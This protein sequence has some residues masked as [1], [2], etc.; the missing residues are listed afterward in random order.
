MGHKVYISFKT[1]DEAYKTYIQAMKGLDYVD[2][3]LNVAIDSDDDDYIMQKIRSDYLS[4]STVTVHLIGNHGAESRGLYE[5]R[6][7]KKELQAS[8][9]HSA[10]NTKNGILGIVLPHANPYIY[11][12]T[13]NCSSCLGSHNHVAISDNTTISEFRYNYYIPHNKCAHHEDDRFCVLVAWDDF[14]KNPNFYIDQAYDKRSAPIASKT[15]V[16]P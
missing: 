7:I 10:T 1:E 16:R 6:Y 3:S 13:Y 15:K 12:G 11:L 2:K 9:Y 5:Q 14:V 8:L 4:D